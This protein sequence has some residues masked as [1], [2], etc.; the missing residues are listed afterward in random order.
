MYHF[1]TIEDCLA[2]NSVSTGSSQQ[3]GNSVM[4]GVPS[5]PNTSNFQTGLFD[6]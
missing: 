5:I 6:L 3:S 2:K 1:Q 4:L